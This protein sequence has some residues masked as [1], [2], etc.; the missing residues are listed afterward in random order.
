ME[1][2]PIRCRIPHILHS[3][4]KTQSWLSD[5]TGLSKQRVSDY[6]TLRRIM[7]IK[8]AKLIAH[9]LRCSIDDLYEWEWQRK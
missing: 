9:V 7:S 3:I 5:H 6:A 2:V 1:P 8:A 4:G